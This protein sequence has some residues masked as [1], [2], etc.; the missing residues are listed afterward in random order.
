MITSYAAMTLK[1][2]YLVI[3]L[4]FPEGG[5]EQIKAP[6]MAACEEAE[7]LT[8]E[9]YNNYIQWIGCIAE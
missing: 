2:F 9:Q 1:S 8:I 6:S 3:M 7:R 4:S 5:Y